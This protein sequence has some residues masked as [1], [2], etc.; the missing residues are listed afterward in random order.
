VCDDVAENWRRKEI[1]TAR[2]GHA[3]GVFRERGYDRAGLA[4]ESENPDAIAFYEQLGM[5]CVRQHDEYERAIGG[6]H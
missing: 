3:S 2:L 5:Q 1:C 4:V 6:H